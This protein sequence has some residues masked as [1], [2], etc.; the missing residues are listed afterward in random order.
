MRLLRI[1]AIS[2]VLVGTTVST[3]SVAG[4]GVQL[5]VQVTKSIVGTPPE[6][7]EYVVEITCDI[8]SAVPDE[9]TFTGDG[10]E[11]VQIPSGATCT[12]TES[13]TGGATQT[14]TTAECVNPPQFCEV[15]V[16]SATSATV[17]LEPPDSATFDAEVVFVNTFEPP[18]PPP[19][20]APPVEAAPSFT[21]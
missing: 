11:I 16:T 6:G 1:L 3:M 13:G 14:A 8:G 17:T 21:G 12:F 5:P 2:C 15:E 19:P 10:S 18:Q 7:A 9:L 20:P 4:G